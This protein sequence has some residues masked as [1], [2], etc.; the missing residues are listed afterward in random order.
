MPAI[1][2]LVAVATANVTV[3]LGTLPARKA[4]PSLGKILGEDLRVEARL[5]DEVL[6]VAARDVPREDL[7]NRISTVL[8]AQWERDAKG[9]VLRRPA[10]VQRALEKEA[11]ERRVARF[12]TIFRDNRQFLSKL[13]PPDGRADEVIRSLKEMVERER[14]N[15]IE[16]VN[17]VYEPKYLSPSAILLRQIMDRIGAR[18]LAGVTGDVV[19]TQSPNAAQRRVDMRA[20]LDEYRTTQERLAAGP[21][22]VDGV[23]PGISDAVFGP[24]RRPVAI[25]KAIFWFGATGGT[26]W[27][28][29]RVY[30]TD[31]RTFDNAVIREQFDEGVPL[32]G[33]TERPALAKAAAISGRLAPVSQAAADLIAQS[34]ADP[35]A[36]LVGNP[37]ER[38][39][40][41]EVLQ[42]V[43]HPEDVEPLGLAATD[44]LRGLGEGKS[45]V[46][47][48]PDSLFRYAHIAAQGDRIRLSAF[49][50]MARDL[51]DIEFA[52]EDGWLTVRSMDPL[53]DA[54]QRLPRAALGTFLR[55]AYARREA[56]VRS[57]AVYRHR[58]DGRDTANSIDRHY[59]RVAAFAGA[60]PV[61]GSFTVPAGFWRLLG[62][63][64]DAAWAALVD[65][66]TVAVGRLPDARRRIPEWAR[67]VGERTPDA[68]GAQATD[69]WLEVTECTAGVPEAATLRLSS[70]GRDLVERVRSTFTTAEPMIVADRPRPMNEIAQLIDYLSR[71]A[72]GADPYS[73]LP[74]RYVVGS[75]SIHDF[76]L[77]LAPGVQLQSQLPLRPKMAAGDG[78]PWAELPVSLR[79]EVSR[80]LRELAKSR[81]KE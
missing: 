46:A 27:A 11:R 25:G 61:F 58:A 59:Q 14:T 7:L 32:A 68:A 37:A 63:L 41:A 23:G 39:V 67:T 77:H 38:A 4:I 69:L 18:E 66:Q 65:G 5:G 60:I 44:A 21:R 47:C 8:R 29:L 20:F 28:A 9:R 24:V 70:N 72:K 34:P 79:D 45:I 2:M 26:F 30:G 53:R 42:T 48:L 51:G 3:D 75:Q 81:D 73:F 33:R 62:A 15:R 71:E 19:Y 12:E 57:Y 22:E 52:R 31:G 16:V 50:T 17:G 49:E 56:T 80:H 36:M 78:V 76:V 40:P 54:A 74:G 43:L 1:L 10:Q 13:P 64:P 35:D 6:L 55:E